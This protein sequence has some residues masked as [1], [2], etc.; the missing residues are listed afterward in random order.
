MEYGQAAASAVQL[1]KNAISGRT[2]ARTLAATI[3]TI[4]T[5]TTWLRRRTTTT[6][7]TSRKR[8]RITPHPSSG[9]STHKSI[10]AL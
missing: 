9:S 6:T 1:Y 3:T 4:T 7:T 5:T 10:I 2:T 8:R